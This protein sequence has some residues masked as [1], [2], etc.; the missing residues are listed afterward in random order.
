M[1]TTTV[2]VNA[3]SPRGGEFVHGHPGRGKSELFAALSSSAPFPITADS[4][5]AL[6][7]QQTPRPSC[8][9]ARAYAVY[10]GGGLEM[11]SA[12]RIA[13]PHRSGLVKG[14]VLASIVALWAFG[15]ADPAAAATQVPGG[16]YSVNTTW[17]PAGSPYILNGSLSVAA[18]AT[19]TI[20]PGVVVK[21]NGTYR[22]LTVNGRLVAEG[23]TES[24]ILFT[25]AQDD[26]PEAGGDTNGDGNATLPAP[27]QWY[28]IWIRS[29]G[30]SFKHAE[31]RYGATGSGGYYAYGAV[32]VSGGTTTFE[33][34]S[35]HDNAYSGIKVT[36][37][38]PQATKA[39]VIESSLVENGNGI[40]ANQAHFEVRR[41]EIARNRGDGLFFNLTSTYTAPA[42]AVINNKISSNGRYGVYL[43]VNQGIPVSS[44]P[45]GHENN[46][47]SNNT[48]NPANQP[49]Q[50]YSLFHHRDMDWS[51]NYWGVKPAGAVQETECS[52][53]PPE[54]NPW[55]LSYGGPGIVAGTSASVPPG[56]IN[57]S[58]H[59][60]V[61][62][63]VAY[64]CGSDYVQGHPFSPVPF[65]TPVFGFEPMTPAEEQNAAINHYRPLLYF[66]EAEHWQPVSV[67]AFFGERHPEAVPFHQACSSSGCSPVGSIAD[68][69]AFGVV[70]HIDVGQ[71][72]DDPPG[73]W[74]SPSTFSGGPCAGSIFLD[75]MGEPYSILYYNRTVVDAADG[76]DEV[77]S[78]W[79]YWW[80][81]R[82]ND[83]TVYPVGGDH[84]GDW[85]G[86]TVVTFAEQDEG[87]GPTGVL[88]VTYSEHG[89]SFR[90]SPAVLGWEALHPKGYPSDGSHATYPYP[91]ASGFPDNCRHDAFPEVGGDGDHGG[92]I[93]WQQNL[94][95][96]GCV[97]P[98]PETAAAASDPT[99]WPDE[100][101][102]SWN[103]LDTDWGASGTPGFQGRYV[104]PWVTET[105]PSFASASS[106]RRKAATGATTID[107]ADCPSWF[108]PGVV[109]LV[110]DEAA[111]QRAL[112]DNSF[113]R[114][115]GKVGIR[116]AAAAKVGTTTGLAQALG[117]RVLRPGERVRLTGSIPRRGKLA[118]RVATGKD[119]VALSWFPLARFMRGPA[120]VRVTGTLRRPQVSLELQ[121]GR[122]VPSRSVRLLHR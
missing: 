77:R 32:S 35:I 81:Y 47:L 54:R 63:Q 8:G 31:I 53:V 56:P 38:E 80:F 93:Q 120:T 15:S 94:S 87:P 24:P 49:R 27:G 13:L 60:T 86:M 51:N 58:S 20:Q 17:T 114:V 19:L 57:F 111:M 122:R 64:W 1:T 37:N 42:T 45:Y 110:C 14:V 108:G 76:G 72:G 90:Y 89:R 11:F 115:R 79:D 92:E 36:Q 59:Y 75:C 4:G 85:E 91:C 41:S 34:V 104:R 61:V 26:A 2:P 69:L 98:F 70:D 21:L 99:V 65:K 28:Q 103:A 40:S 117:R 12:V 84:E 33:R 16:T 88:W 6:G 62:G 3:G 39:I 71:T 112:D 30:S 83:F 5:I 113:G 44:L 100:G 66:D 74:P 101:R 10:V 25:S 109:A 105:G 68:L 116:T 52:W 50:L 95:C 82:Y 67:D 9:R 22:M 102:A 18:G 43:G 46:I 121:S 78:Y 107:E 119:L 48:T 23:T 55:H 73:G 96:G 29:T 106:A 118:V 97:Q 7:E